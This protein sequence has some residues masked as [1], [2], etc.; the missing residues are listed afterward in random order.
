MSSAGIEDLQVVTGS[1]K[2]PYPKYFVGEEKAEEIAE[3]VRPPVHLLFCLIISSP[4][5]VEEA[6]SVGVNA[7]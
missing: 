1:R 2:V 6:W 7:E 5:A 3:V 4:S